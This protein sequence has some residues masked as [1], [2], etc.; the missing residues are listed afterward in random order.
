MYKEDEIADAHERYKELAALSLARVLSGSEQEELSDHLRACEECREVYGE[1]RVLMKEGLSKLGPRYEHLRGESTGLDW[2]GT[3]ARERILTHVRATGKEA[4][5]DQNVFKFA[6]P[7][8]RDNRRY[9]IG[10]A[11]RWITLAAGITL[12]VGLGAYQY[13][14]RGVVDALQS[15]ASAAASAEQRVR[16]LGVEK[17][18][19][20]ALLNSQAKEIAALQEESSQKE[21][22]I[23]KLRSDLQAANDYMAQLLAAKS[24]TDE[25]L[26]SAAQHIEALNKQLSETQQ[27]YR[28]TQSELATLRTQRDTASSRLDSLETDVAILSSTNRDL[29]RQ[30]K[31]SEQYLSSDRDIRELMGARNLYIADVFDVDSRSRTRRPYGRIFYTQGKSLIFYAFD[32]DHQAHVL[33]T[34]SFQAW[35]QKEVPQ[36]IQSKPVS[37]GIFYLDSVSN[38]RWTMRCDNPRDLAE[39]DAVFVTVEPQGGSPKPTGKPLLYAMLRKEVNHP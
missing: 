24:N 26:R 11:T 37:L 20:D 14:K 25:Q 21:Q 18:A 10:A 23:A 30:L 38:R 39:I 27:A 15:F 19:D 13:G 6:D 8:S 3:A 12:V 35:G 28:G 17:S 22:R 32:L 29:E 5:F 33:N 34:S 2:D 16:N 9:H 4:S 1:Y 36:G 31:N 7:E